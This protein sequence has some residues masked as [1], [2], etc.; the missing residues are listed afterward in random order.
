MV[1]FPQAGFSAS[2]RTVFS[3]LDGLRSLFNR[4]YFPDLLLRGRK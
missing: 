3:L 1:A 2:R 4:A